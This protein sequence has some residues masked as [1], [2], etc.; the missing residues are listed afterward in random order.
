MLPK[1]EVSCV[2]FRPLWEDFWSSDHLRQMLTFS[3]LVL[4]PAAFSKSDRLNPGRIGEN[5]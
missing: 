1:L 2:D 4:I 5:L 3:R